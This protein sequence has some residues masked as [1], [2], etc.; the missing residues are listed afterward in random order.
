[1]IHK[2]DDFKQ[3]T[4][5]VAL[6]KGNLVTENIWKHPELQTGNPGMYKTVF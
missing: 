6:I 5:M 1:M 4:I 3:F 2:C